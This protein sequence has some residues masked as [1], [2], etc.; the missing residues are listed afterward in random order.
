MIHT[1]IDVEIYSC[2]TRIKVHRQRNANP[3]IGKRGDIVEFSNRSRNR[4]LFAAFN[5]RVE[6]SA[7]VTLTYPAEFPTDGCVV[8]KDRNAFLTYLRREYSDIAYLWAL[9]FQ[10]RGAPHIHFLAD[11]FIDLHWLSETWYQVVGSQDEKHLRAGTQVES[12]RGRE[13]G[14]SYMAKSYTGKRAQKQVPPEYMN[15]GRFWGTSRGLV[16]VQRFATFG[17]DLDGVF[18]PGGVQIV[19]ALRRFVEKTVKVKRSR[20]MSEHHS[21]K[22]CVKRK[23]KLPHLHTGLNGFTVFRGAKVTAQLL[24][25]MVEPTKINRGEK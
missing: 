4:L 17:T 8:R 6:W 24:D 16:V 15:V 23:V 25:A 20:P 18:E 7:F 13:Q 2:D 3:P 14:A 21:R 10:A 11:Q 22:R 5:A 9:E 12:V 1:G 19:R